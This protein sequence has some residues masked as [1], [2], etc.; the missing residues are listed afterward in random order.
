LTGKIPIQKS[1]SAIPLGASLSLFSTSFLLKIFFSG[2]ILSRS[3]V[4]VTCRRKWILG[5]NNGLA[6]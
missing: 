3:G 4:T 1:L 5:R 2:N 6:T